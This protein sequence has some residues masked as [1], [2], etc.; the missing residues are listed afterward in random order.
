MTNKPKVLLNH[1]V[2]ASADK[3]LSH[4]DRPAAQF[5][6][7][8]QIGNEGSIRRSVPDQP[9]RSMVVSPC[10][11]ICS[12]FVMLLRGVGRHSLPLVPDSSDA[13]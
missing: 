6:S 4:R 12:L 7:E 11:S 13:P 1:S 2:L 3:I 8:S 5:L 9:E 10:L